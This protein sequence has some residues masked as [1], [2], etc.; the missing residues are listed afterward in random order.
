MKSVFQSKLVDVNGFV[1]EECRCFIPALKSPKASAA[2][3]TSGSSIDN[4]LPPL[5]P[6]L[7]GVSISIVPGESIE[8][9]FGDSCE[10]PD[11]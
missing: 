1:D 2:I 5:L 3:R 4:T 11:W 6:L 8:L 10:G 9:F 7:S